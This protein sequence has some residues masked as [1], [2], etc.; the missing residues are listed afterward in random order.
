[1]AKLDWSRPLPKPIDIG[2]RALRTLD[3]VRAHILKL[4]PER[5]DKPVWHTVADELLKAA[6]GGDVRGV[7]ATFYVANIIDRETQ[8]DPRPPAE[9]S[10]TGVKVRRYHPKGSVG[11][12]RQSPSEP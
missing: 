4:P 6:K 11:H 9:A 3:D 10:D 2:E 1:M 7:A 8:K 12:P 5:R